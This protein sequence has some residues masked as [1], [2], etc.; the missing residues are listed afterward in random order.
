MV[1]VIFA[2]ATFKSPC[3]FRSG[4]CKAMLLNCKPGERKGQYSKW[5]TSRILPL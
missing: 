1:F 2:G 4:H 5:E 3:H